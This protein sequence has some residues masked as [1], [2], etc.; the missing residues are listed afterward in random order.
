MVGRLVRA[1][2]HSVGADG[3]M[4]CSC[5]FLIEHGITAQLRHMGIH[6]ESQFADDPVLLR[7]SCK[8]RGNFFPVAA[9]NLPIYDMQGD[10][11]CENCK[12]EMKV[13]NEGEKRKGV[14]GGL[15]TGF[16]SSDRQPD[17]PA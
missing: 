5:H 14:L 13:I 7:Q 17:R 16:S 9:G 6:P 4:E 3:D 8:V 10:I 11:K 15:Q 2:K 12:R 1:S